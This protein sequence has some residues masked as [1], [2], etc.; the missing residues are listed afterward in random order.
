M[1]GSLGG[2]Y[3][4]IELKLKA[5]GNNV[6]KLFYVKPGADPNQIKIS[7]SGLQPPESLLS[8]CGH[9][10]SGFIKGD[11]G[12]YFPLLRGLGYGVA[13]PGYR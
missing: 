7:L 6:E 8:A 2:V 12:G 13:A 11:L 9:A 10:Q 5:H 1:G 4:G 3:E